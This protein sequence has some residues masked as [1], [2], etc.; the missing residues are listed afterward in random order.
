MTSPSDT[1]P[2]VTSDTAAY[3]GTCDRC[4]VKS[5]KG[6]CYLATRVP[7]AAYTAGCRADPARIDAVAYQAALRAS[8][9]AD[10]HADSPDG[11]PWTHPDP[12]PAPAGTTCSECQHDMYWTLARTAYICDN[13]HWIISRDTNERIPVT[14]EIMRRKS[15][16]PEPDEIAWQITIN[17]ILEN[18][19]EELIRECTQYECMGYINGLE[20]NGVSVPLSEYMRNY[21]TEHISKSVIDTFDNMLT[22]AREMDRANQRWTDNPERTEEQI[23]VDQKIESLYRRW[24]SRGR[25]GP[26]ERNT[27]GIKFAIE[28]SE[29]DHY[30]ELW[31]M[32]ATLLNV[33]YVEKVIEKTKLTIT[34]AI[35]LTDKEIS[36]ELQRAA[37]ARREPTP[38]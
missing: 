19:R 3:I 8:R 1:R 24:V 20:R 23:E 5:G 2:A 14:G 6:T 28:R 12:D 35:I 11:D 31:E 29:R 37:I 33:S 21:P 15:K 9:R 26:K 18:R 38:W 25:P 32:S 16:D 7:R 17:Q 4:P 13:N 34:I 22:N 36:N 10:S 27:I 30:R